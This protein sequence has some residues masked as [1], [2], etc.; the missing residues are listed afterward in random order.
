MRNGNLRFPITLLMTGLLAVVVFGCRKDEGTS[1]AEPE[2][3][4]AAPTD[5]EGIAAYEAI[6]PAGAVPSAWEQSGP[7][8]VYPGKKLYDSIDGAADRFF[9]YTFREQY[10]VGNAS[11]DPGK[12]V[13]VEVYDMGNP[14]DAFGIFSCHDNIMSQRANIGLAGVVSEVNL[15]FCQGKYFVRLQAKGFEGGEADKPLRAFAEAMAG[16]IKPP[17]EL[18]ELVRCLPEGHVAGTVLFFHT[19]QTLNEKRYIAE[20]NVFQLDE[21]TKGV[22]AAYSSEEKKSEDFSLKLEKD[23]VFLLEYSDKDKAQSART[24]YIK[25]LQK[26]VEDS[27]AEGQPES[28][29]LQLI[30]FPQEPLEIYQLYKGE[31]AEKH[32]A[33]IVHVFR[34]FVFGIWEVTTE[35]KAKGILK[36]IAD[37]LRR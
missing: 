29:R 22:L 35:E 8:R 28:G 7:V 34:N 26:V 17:A 3:P 16:N 19:G 37:D 14:E 2:E 31:G 25:H 4:G 1:T 20:E 11:K 36:R 32:V 30:G 5:K 21:K 23:I 12:N 24:S 15:D 13:D 33:S 6:L 10:V 18:P 27:R 9:Q